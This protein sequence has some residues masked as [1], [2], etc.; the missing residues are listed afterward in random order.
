MQTTMIGRCNNMS[1]SFSIFMTHFFL[2]LFFFLINEHPILPLPLIL[3]AA[4]YRKYFIGIQT[5]DIS[6]PPQLALFLLRPSPT[7]P[8]PNSRTCAPAPPKGTS[9]ISPSVSI[10]S[11]GPLRPSLPFVMK[12]R[13][14]PFL[15]LSP[16]HPPFQDD[17]R[18]KLPQCNPRLL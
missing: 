1:L 5:N 13:P 14:Q 6:I 9:N 12:S 7:T 18:F 3:V 4:G 2:L 8:L 15:L 17:P 11:D 16:S 10:L